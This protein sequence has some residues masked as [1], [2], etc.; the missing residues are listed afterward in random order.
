[1]ERHSSDSNCVSNLWIDR[2][3]MIELLMLILIRQLLMM[4]D[5]LRMM[6][7]WHGKMTVVVIILIIVMLFRQLVREILFFRCRKSV[8][9]WFRWIL[10]EQFVLILAFMITIKWFFMRPRIFLPFF[11]FFW[12]LFLLFL[13]FRWFIVSFRV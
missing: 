6:I 3:Q 5:I 10:V 4:L 2:F 8:F 7:S 11:F 9:C 12:R 13:F 1:M